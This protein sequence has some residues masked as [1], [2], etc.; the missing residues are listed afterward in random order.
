MKKW[1][2]IVAICIIALSC[3][4][5]DPGGDNPGEEDTSIVMYIASEKYMVTEIPGGVYYFNRYSESGVFL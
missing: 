2:L 5:K 3:T 1:L 4:E